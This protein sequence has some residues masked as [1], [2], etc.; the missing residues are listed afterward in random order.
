MDA[1]AIAAPG[2]LPLSYR[3][4]ATHVEQTVGRL[5]ALG[6]GQH[7]R[8]VTVLGNGPCAASGFLAVATAA[9]AAPLNPSFRTDELRE[10]LAELAPR[11]VIAE[12]GAPALATAAELG[13]ATAELVE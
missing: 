5:R 3:E 4:L 2:R 11:L 13:M 7:D 8:V 12:P 6:V 1:S 9:C 10:H